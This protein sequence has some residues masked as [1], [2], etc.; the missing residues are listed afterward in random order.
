MTTTATDV[1]AAVPGQPRAIELLR[2]DVASGRVAHAYLF[3]G[4]AGRIPRDAALAFAAALVCADHGCGACEA[5]VRV[6]HHGHPDVDLLEPAGMQVLVDQVRDAVRTSSRRPV[7]ASRRVIIVDQADRLTPTAQNAF[8]KALEEP[9]PSTTIVLLAPGPED[10]LETVRSR[11]REV[12]FRTPPPDEVAGLLEREGVDAASALRWARVAGGADRAR[13]LALDEQAREARGAIVDRILTP[14]RD[15]G[16]ALE[17]AERLAERA[18][19]TRERVAA[20]HR[21]HQ[22]AFGDWATEAKRAADDRLRREQRRAEQEELEAAI[23]DVCAVLRDLIAVAAG[24]AASLLDES[25]ADRLSERVRALGPHASARALGALHDVER[26][27]R[28]LR[29]NANVLLTLEEVFL[30]VQR[31]LG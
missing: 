1:W 18:K 20:A 21:E 26:C 30:S 14:F 24:E 17:A 4:S 10:L 27:R 16:D 8:L 23:D 28:R 11:C 31:H 9:P 29:L 6:R 7:A 13:D 15:P 12:A 3:G 25:L 5:C 2:G 19:L 22:E